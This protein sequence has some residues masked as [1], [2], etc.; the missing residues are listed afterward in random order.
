MMGQA[1]VLKFLKRR[2]QKG[3]RKYY[4]PS[5]ITRL[6]ADELKSY[7]VSNSCRKLLSF[8][9]VTSKVLPRK[10]GWTIRGYRYNPTK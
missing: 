3:T 8:G 4:P 1:E 5:E 10:K 7:N 9:F 2:W 6:M